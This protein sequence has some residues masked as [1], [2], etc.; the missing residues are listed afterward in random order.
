MHKNPT[1]INSSVKQLRSLISEFYDIVLKEHNLI[2][3][4]LSTSKSVQSNKLSSEVLR[5]RLELHRIYNSLLDDVAFVIAQNPN[6][7]DLR[8]T[9]SYAQMSKSLERLGNYASSIAF[10]IINNHDQ[11]EYAMTIKK[12]F[13][14]AYKNLVAL[15]TIFESE[16][17]DEII[18]LI[19]SDDEVDKLYKDSLKKLIAHKQSSDNEYSL[20]IKVKAIIALR[21]IERIGDQVTSIC[22]ALYYIS[23]GKRVDVWNSVLD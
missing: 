19:Q 17:T 11:P 12:V 15:K 4:S 5:N 18:T 8:R 9:L 20:K 6:G 16:N 2:K 1:I 21:A 22:E 13:N 7:K 14:S 23:T 10:F 3:R